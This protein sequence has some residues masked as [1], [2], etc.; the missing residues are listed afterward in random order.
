M[1]ACRL[2]VPADK[3]VF[4]DDS[5]TNV[6]AACQLGWTGIHFKNAEQLQQE[7]QQC[8]VNFKL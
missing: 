6:R 5:E 4:I 3:L 2:N 7:L 8:G 1:H